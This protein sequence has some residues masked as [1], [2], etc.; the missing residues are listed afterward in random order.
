MSIMKHWLEELSSKSKYKYKQ[1]WH[2]MIYLLILLN[3]IDIVHYLSLS[4]LSSFVLRKTEDMKQLNRIL[5][6][7][8]TYFADQEVWLEF[9]LSALFSISF[10]VSLMLIHQN[11]YD[12]RQPM[13]VYLNFLFLL[14]KRNLLNTNWPVKLDCFFKLDLSEWFIEEIFFVV[15]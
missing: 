13:I 8:H 10:C 1:Q 4:I 2:W 3:L 15:E 12:H 14:D 9:S 11:R 5:V 6:R 7:N